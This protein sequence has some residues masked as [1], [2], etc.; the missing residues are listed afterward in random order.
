MDYK[1][2]HDRVQ[3]AAYS[4]I[5][6]S[7]KKEFHLTIGRLLFKNTTDPEERVFEIANHL[8]A[9]IDLIIEKEE[10]INL[11]NLNLLAGVKAKN[12]NAENTALKHFSIGLQA[13]SQDDWHTH[14]E[15]CFKLHREAALVEYTTGNFDKGKY[16]FATTLKNTKS[17][18]DKAEIFSIEMNLY[19]TQGDFKTGVDAGRKA[20][21][22]R[23]DNEFGPY[24]SPMED[25]M[26]HFHEWYRREMGAS[27]T[28]QTI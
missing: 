6:E 10:K 20:L 7:S 16:L 26:Q 12:S 1:F 18:L 24:Q 4:L 14:Y 28:T 13:L 2:A 8:N 22:D 11:A 5:D 9:G 21:L 15:L 23:G 25:G 17:N 27:K 19:M 3:Q